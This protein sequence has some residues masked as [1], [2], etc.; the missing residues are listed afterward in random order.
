MNRVVTIVTRHHT[1]RLLP[2][3]YMAI[4][5]ANIFYE[6]EAVRKFVYKLTFKLFKTAF[7]GCP[8]GFRKEE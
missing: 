5:A 3:G 4:G 8:R 6:E 2:W 7:T 1:L